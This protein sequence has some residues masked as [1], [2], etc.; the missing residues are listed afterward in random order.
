MEQTD[1]ANGTPY[2]SF[3]LF[4]PSGFHQNFIRVFQQ[5]LLAPKKDHRLFF[6]K[7]MV[8]KKKM[9]A[10]FKNAVVFELKRQGVF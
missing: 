7:M 6:K 1:K 10:F 9:T 8:R 3:H 5:E 4:T 2:P